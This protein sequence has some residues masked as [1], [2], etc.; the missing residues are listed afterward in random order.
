MNNFRTKALNLGKKSK[1]IVLDCKIKPQKK[2]SEDILEGMLSNDILNNLSNQ[3]I[4]EFVSNVGTMSDNITNTYAMV[5]EQTKLMMEAMSLTN[6]ILDFADTRINQLES[7][8]NLI[9]LIACHRDWI[10]LFI[11][12]LTIQLGEEQLKDA[13]NAIE[14]FRGGTDLSEQERNSLEKLRVLLHD[15][16]MSTDDIKLLRKLVKN[17]SNTLFHKNNQTIEQAKAQLND[18][19]PEC[20]R[21]YKFPLRKALK[22]ISF[23]RK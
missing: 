21:I 1:S 5:E 17:Y 9:K 19:L 6:E 22:A 4:N 20:M 11:E 14:L 7:N 12:K 16:E 23:W 15:R 13:E 10:K 2:Q 8:L 18:P 3:Q